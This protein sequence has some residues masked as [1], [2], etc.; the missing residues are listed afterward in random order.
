[1]PI[2]KETTPPSPSGDLVYFSLD[3]DAD[4]S[5]IETFPQFIQ[6]KIKKSLTYEQLLAAKGAPKEG[7]FGPMDNDSPDLPF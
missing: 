4:L 5:M 2:S 1:M 7:D 3:K 6:D